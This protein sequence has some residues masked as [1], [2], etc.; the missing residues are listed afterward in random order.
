MIYL[1]CSGSNFNESQ[2][3]GFV[4]KQPKTQQQQQSQQSTDL[5][6]GLGNV[7]AAY[8]QNLLET[9]QVNVNL[10]RIFF[11]TFIDVSL[12]YFKLA[13]FLLE[14]IIRIRVVIRK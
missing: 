14:N 4:E 1:I 6:T 5:V 11:Q 10:I 2:L 13:T 3:Q 9:P 7:T 12:I 8:Q